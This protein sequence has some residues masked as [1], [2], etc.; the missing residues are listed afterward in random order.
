MF[1]SSWPYP[2]VCTIELISITAIPPY[3]LKKLWSISIFPA[4]LVKIATLLTISTFLLTQAINKKTKTDFCDKGLKDP[5]KIL[6]KK[7][8]LHYTACSLVKR[9]KQQ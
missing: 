3:L 1:F 7:N 6:G 8:L 9:I 4:C 2:V 5:V